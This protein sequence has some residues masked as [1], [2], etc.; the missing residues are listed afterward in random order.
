MALY[1]LRHEHAP[2]ACPGADPQY[3]PML[4]AHVD[5]GEARRRY[6]VD[7]QAEAVIR[8]AHTLFMIVDSADPAGLEAFLTP[9]RQFGP[10]EALASSACDAVVAAGGC[11]ALA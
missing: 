1:V 3:G 8:G 10:T 4:L 5:R 11:A 9:F 2:E 7:I 6:G